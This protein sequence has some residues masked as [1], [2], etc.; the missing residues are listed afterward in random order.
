[1]LQ[2]QCTSPC[3]AVIGCIVLWQALMLSHGMV[4]LAKPGMQAASARTFS[5][6]CDCCVQAEVTALAQP[7]FEG[8]EVDL[9]LKVRHTFFQAFCQLFK[10]PA[11]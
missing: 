1:M 8:C 11:F 9:E 10:L 2:G 5:S 3:S 6:A 4:R 7:I